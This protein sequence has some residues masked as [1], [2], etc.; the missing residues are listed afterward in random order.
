MAC[1]PYRAGPPPDGKYCDCVGLQTNPVVPSDDA[2][3]Y[4]QLETRTLVPIRKLKFCGL[5]QQ[6]RRFENA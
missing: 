3:A 5:P 4:A 1:S 6:A 2:E